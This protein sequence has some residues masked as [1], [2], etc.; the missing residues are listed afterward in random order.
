MGDQVHQPNLN[1]AP[2][3]GI[4]WD[5]CK[6]GKTVIRA[7]GGIYYE[8][9]VWNNVLFDAPARLQTGTVLGR[10]QTTC[11][12]P[13]SFCGQPIGSV[14]KQIVAAQQAYQAATLA[15]GPAANGSYI[16]NTLS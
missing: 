5:P 14:Y 16:G 7:G 11:G 13:P 3:V 15:A 10:M 12:D 2:Q 1:F 9:T 6:N 8:N 4:A